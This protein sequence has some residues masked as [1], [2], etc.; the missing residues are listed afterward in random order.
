MEYFSLKPLKIKNNKITKMDKIDLVRECLDKKKPEESLKTILIR[1][2]PIILDFINKFF[3]TKFNED[4]LFFMNEYYIRKAGRIDL[5]F[6]SYTGNI[7]VIELK[8]EDNRRKALPQIVE[9]VGAIKGMDGANIIG[10]IKAKNLKQ[11]SNFLSLNN[12]DETF[13]EKKINSNIRDKK[14]LAII[15]YNQ[16]NETIAEKFNNM[17][18]DYKDE[19]S[20]NLILAELPS[21]LTEDGAI[22][23]IPYIHRQVSRNLEVGVAAILNDLYKDIDI[24]KNIICKADNTFMELNNN[25]TSLL[26]LFYKHVQCESEKNNNDKIQLKDLIIAEA[27]RLKAKSFYDLFK[28]TCLDNRIPSRTKCYEILGAEAINEISAYLLPRFHYTKEK[29]VA[30]LINLSRELG[31][32]PTSKECKEKN[33]PVSTINYYFNSYNAALKAAGLKPVMEH[34]RPT[35]EEIRNEIITISKLVKKHVVR[36]YKNRGGR[37][38]W[39]IH[40]FGSFRNALKSCG[41]I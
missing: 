22:I 26:E 16:I 40:Y 13:L 14:I 8:V 29:I 25:I 39:Y 28:Y 30:F 27:T 5:L 20:Y 32:T 41:V 33:L 23:T 12:I 19:I 34:K 17:I 2:K 3:N 31:R 37:Y 10:K 6:I 35:E 24:V 9:Y 11:F 21:F 1:F 4:N 38:Y 36:E 7:V 15:I 18:K